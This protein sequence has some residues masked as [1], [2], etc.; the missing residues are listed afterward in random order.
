M[1]G[2][3]HD[4]QC[5]V[6]KGPHEKYLGHEVCYGY[7]EDSLVRANCFSH[8]RKTLLLITLSIDHLRRH[9]QGEP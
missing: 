5:L 6:Y 8:M 7:N 2:Y 4:A 9:R 3:V 1:D